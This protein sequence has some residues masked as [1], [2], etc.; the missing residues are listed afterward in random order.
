MK[1]DRILVIPFLIA[2]TLLSF[3]PC[4]YAEVLQ[5]QTYPAYKAQNYEMLQNA[6]AEQKRQLV[7][8]L[9]DVQRRAMKIKKDEFTLSF[10]KTI[11]AFKSVKNIENFPNKLVRKTDQLKKQYEEHFIVN[12]LSFYDLLFIDSKGAIF[13]TIRKQKDY[14]MNIFEGQLENTA[15]SKKMKTSPSTSFVDFQFYE[16]SGE[17]SAFFIEPVKDEKEQ[18]G[19]VVLQFSIDKINNMFCLAQEIGKTYE[20]FLVNRSKYMLTDS[21]FIT[22]STILKEQL[23]EENIAAKFNVRKGHKEVTDYR[24]HKVLSTFE[25]FN[26]LGSEW[27]II[28]KID[29]E[30]LFTNYFK[31]HPEKLTEILEKALSQERESYHKGKLSIDSG[32]E[33]DMDEFRRND[34]DRFLYTHGVSSCTAFIIKKLSDFTYFAHIS[35]FDKVYGE[36]RTDL[37][38][39]ML[40]KIE[41]LEVTESE[42]HKLYFYIVSP[43]SAAFEAIIKRLMK[44]GYFLSQIK[45][46]HYKRAAYA[47]VSSKNNRKE[48]LVNWKM[49]KDLYYLESSNERAN[50][51]SLMREIM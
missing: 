37:M 45:I 13:Y 20:I 28:S 14:N 11:H 16:I 22:E 29:E 40:K 27:L 33:V 21:R 9:S 25:V 35:P 17:P 41:Y 6:L 47:N 34:D 43:S 24:G 8:F 31:Q 2:A 44:H 49:N 15:L 4:S 18:I 32:I 7:F 50:L 12:Y 48:V 42:K 19:W 46:I 3:Y 30:E 23:A 5:N 38:E 26:F 1:K 39:H 51:Q 36:N 10:F